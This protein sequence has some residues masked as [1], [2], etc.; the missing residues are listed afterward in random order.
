MF[1]NNILKKVVNYFRKKSYNRGDSME[2]VIDVAKDFHLHMM[3]E[4]EFLYRID[5]YRYKNKIPSR[6]EAIRKLIEDSL[7]RA[8]Q[9]SKDKASE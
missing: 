5:E 9:E 1:N 3:L 4:S 2:G 8:E 7:K 6:S